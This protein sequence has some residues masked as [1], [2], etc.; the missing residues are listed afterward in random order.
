MP[1]SYAGSADRIVE[2]LIAYREAGLEYAVIGFESEDVDD[3]IRQ[4]RMFAEAVAPNL[5]TSA[6]TPGSAA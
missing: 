1:G 5:S 3:L 4:M 6:M 2:H